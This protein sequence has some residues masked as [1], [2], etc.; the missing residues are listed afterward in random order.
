VA[1]G[2]VGGFLAGDVGGVAVA[3]HGQVPGLPSRPGVD[4]GVMAE[5][6]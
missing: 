5:G 6:A 4:M 3:A 1:G 2:F